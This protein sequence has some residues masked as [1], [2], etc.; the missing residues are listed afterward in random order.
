MVKKGN[1][2]YV[3][4]FSFFIWFKH[5]NID[6]VSIFFSF[7]IILL[8]PFF[9]SLLILFFDFNRRFSVY[10]PKKV[11]LIRSFDFLSF[12][13]Q[14]THIKTNNLYFDN[15]YDEI[16]PL[17][18]LPTTITHLEF[19][20]IPFDNPIHEFP[21]NLTHLIFK[22]SLFLT[23]PKFP[24]NLKH[25]LIITNNHKTLTNIA[26]I[27]TLTHLSVSSK[28]SQPINIGSPSTW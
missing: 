14:T 21:I 16:F 11:V 20:R 24:P 22:D 17:Y 12:P 25:L 18:T 23:I 27:T 3:W 19:D 9:L 26:S 4:C 5:F 6:F 1:F 15:E 28:A 13:P 2:Y 8:L 7:I 10:N